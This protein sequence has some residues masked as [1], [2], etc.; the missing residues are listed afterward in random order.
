MIWS[1]WW[2]IA[3]VVLVI[4]RAVC[5]WVALGSVWWSIVWPVGVAIMVSIRAQD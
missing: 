5:S 3:T 1:R 4:V 2:D